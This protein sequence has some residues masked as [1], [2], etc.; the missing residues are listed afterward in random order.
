MILR[1]NCANFMANIKNA[2][3]YDF[4]LAIRFLNFIG[5]IIRSLIEISKLKLQNS[6]FSQFTP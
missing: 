5:S 6:N 2:D 3:N 4:S 1:L